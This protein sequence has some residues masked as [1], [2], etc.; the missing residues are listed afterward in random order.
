M[1]YLPIKINAIETNHEYSLTVDSAGM[2]F[3]FGFEGIKTGIVPLLQTFGKQL[4]YGHLTKSAFYTRYSHN[5]NS[6]IQQ[7][8]EANS[9]C[10]WVDQSRLAFYLLMCRT[11]LKESWL[12]PGLISR[13]PDGDLDQETGM[14]RAFASM[15]TQSQPWNHYPV[16]LL[17]DCGAD[18]DLF[19]TCEIIT[20]D[21]QL[22][23]IFKADFQTTSSHKLK[24]Q[25]YFKIWNY[26]N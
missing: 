13:T 2:R 26:R 6:T 8:T 21:R 3:N 9:N 16:L 25:I 1:D 22:H 19:E 4:R 11:A 5:F 20:S 14:S 10:P 18:I 23:Q 24:T 17:D 12:Y 7:L 15:M